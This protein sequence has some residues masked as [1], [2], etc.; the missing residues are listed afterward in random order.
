LTPGAPLLRLGLGAGRRVP[1]REVPMP[2]PETTHP[3]ELQSDLDL[4]VEMAREPKR[5]AAAI[6]RHVESLK[7]KLDK[8]IH[9]RGVH[10]DGGAAA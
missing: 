3:E 6:R 8:F 7:S 1:S 2:D 4:L 10:N 9:E 5:D